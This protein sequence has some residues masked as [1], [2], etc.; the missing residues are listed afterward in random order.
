MCGICG[1]FDLKGENRFPQNKINILMSMADTLKHRGPDDIRYF[2][3]E[4]IGLGFTRLSIIDLEGGYQPMSNEDHTVF[5]ICNGEIFNYKELKR[6]LLQKDH[7]FRTR[8]DVEVILHLYEEYGLDFISSLNGQFAFALYDCRNKKLICARDHVG[9][10]P[11]Y[12]TVVDKMFIFASEIKSIFQHPY[13]KKEIDLTGL[14]QV[15]NFPGIASPRTLF[16]NI[17]SLEPGHFLVVDKDHGIVNKE[18]WDLIYDKDEEGQKEGKEEYYIERLDELLTEAVEKRLQADVPVG[19]YLSGGLDSALIAGKIHQNNKNLERNSYSINF[20]DKTFSEGKYQRLMAQHLNSV[21]HEIPFDIN[22]I[23]ARL[24]KA[25]YHSETALKESYNTASL[26]LSEQVRSDHVKVVLTGEG[27]DELFGGYIGYRF[28]CLKAKQ[29]TLTSASTIDADER[30]IRKQLWGDEIFLYEK[31]HYEYA[32]KIRILYSD[33]VNSRY[34]DFN[35]FRHPLINKERIRG[36]NVFNKRSYIDFKLRMG[37]HLLTDHGDRM[38]LANSVEA[39]YPFLDKDVI[40]FTRKLPTDMKLRN[41]KEKYIVK[42]IAEKTVPK[43]IVNRSK[44]AFVA[45]GSSD[46][47]RLKQEYIMDMLSYE[48][49]KRQGVFNP[50]TVEAYKKQYA[51]ADFKLNVPYDDD[52][53]IIVLTF[54]ILLDQFGMQGSII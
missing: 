23:V 39:R 48:Q 37:D 16:K 15:M 45:P 31:Y 14:D 38:A 54:N 40:E 33:K 53:L 51:Q 29:A 3:D 35:C 34:D 41:Y 10:A 13:V 50:D 24:K 43:E 52:I 44:F 28:D 19:F 9:I 2:M 30:E 32:R 42:K 1:Y 6:E 21:H 11:F 46:L 7:V 22:G 25:V 4:N 27:A 12:Y 49:I 36:I 18:Y 20:T 47:L 5:M 8:C 17:R 26:A